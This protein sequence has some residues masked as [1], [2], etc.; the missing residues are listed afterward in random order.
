[1]EGEH[2]VGKRSTRIS[3]S[4]T[5]FL[6]AIRQ[7]PLQLQIELLLVFGQVIVQ[8]SLHQGEVMQ[9]WDL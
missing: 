4:P 1:L 8:V 5:P 2:F 3:G 9:Q 7:S 6:V